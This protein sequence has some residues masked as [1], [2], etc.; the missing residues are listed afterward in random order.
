MA[1][2]P[3]IEIPENRAKA[4]VMSARTLLSMFTAG[5]HPA[6]IV[7]EESAIPE[8]ALAVMGIWDDNG[9]DG[10]FF[11]RVKSASF[12]EVSFT[13]QTPRFSPVVQILPGKP[14]SDSLEAT[15]LKEKDRE[16]SML[17]E[18]LELATQEIEDLKAVIERAGGTG[19]S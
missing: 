16:I 17:K 3:P 18:S 4:L 9:A 13:D 11:L 2:K 10:A 6:Y 8:D 5:L 19:Q 12:P 7:Q 1:Q 15:V 14:S